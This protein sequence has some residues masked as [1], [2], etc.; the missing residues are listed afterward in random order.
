M[1]GK[2]YQ[3]WG[4]EQCATAGAIGRGYED[5]PTREDIDGGWVDEFTNYLVDTRTTPPEVVASDGGEPEDQTLDR[6][7]SWVAPALN[8]EAER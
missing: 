4:A 8:A 1:S 3:V 7:W 5:A 6:A 2:P